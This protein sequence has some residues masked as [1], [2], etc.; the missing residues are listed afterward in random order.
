M[1][2]F[3]LGFDSVLRGGSFSPALLFAASEPGAFY[4]TSDLSTMFQDSTGTTPAVVGQPVGRVNDKRLGGPGPQLFATGVYDN[5]TAA[6]ST[7]NGRIVFDGATSIANS[8]NIFS[9]NGVACVV[10]Q[11]YIITYTIVADVGLAV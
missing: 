6:A 2:G 5:L 10:G 4:D 7:V 8:S 1:L 11:T 3:S 9:P